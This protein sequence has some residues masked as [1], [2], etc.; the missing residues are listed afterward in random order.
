MSATAS[1]DIRQLRRVRNF[2]GIRQADIQAAL[3]I[4][5][6]RLSAA[7]TGKIDLSH[8]ER[9]ALKQFLLDRSRFLSAVESEMFAEENV[10]A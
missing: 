8:T 1:A 5:V 6:A 3:G 10:V 9:A 2:L 4:P 7:E